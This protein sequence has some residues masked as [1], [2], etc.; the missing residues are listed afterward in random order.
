MARLSNYSAGV[1]EHVLLA[2]QEFF[3][4]LLQTRELALPLP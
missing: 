2:L 3:G 4:L 1:L